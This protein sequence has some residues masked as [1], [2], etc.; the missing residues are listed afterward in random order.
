MPTVV[1]TDTPDEPDQSTEQEAAERKAAKKAA[2]RAKRKAA[3]DAP[4]VTET[5]YYCP[6]CGRRWKFLTECQG[7]TP[8]APHPPILVVDTDEL[9]GDPADHTPAPS[10]E[11]ER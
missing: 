4:E 9:D 11:P 8:A 3:T 6:G 10:T 2:K 1:N 5:P 7:M